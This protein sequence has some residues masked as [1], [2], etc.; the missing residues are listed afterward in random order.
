MV[1]A[2]GLPQSGRLKLRVDRNESVV[3]TPLNTGRIN[4]GEAGVDDW[5]GCADADRDL[6][7]EVARLRLRVL[8]LGGDPFPEL[9]EEV[10]GADPQDEAAPLEQGRVGVR[11]HG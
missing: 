4:Q 8:S 3:F 2:G 5:V 1:G 10:G 9:H 11:R 6:I 7:R